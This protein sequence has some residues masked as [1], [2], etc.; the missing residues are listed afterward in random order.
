MMQKLIYL[1]LALFII[2]P[3]PAARAQNVEYAKNAL[4]DKYYFVTESIRAEGGNIFVSAIREF[5]A[6]RSGAV[7][8]V[9]AVVFNSGEKTY[10]LLAMAS[11]G[12]GGNVL[13]KQAY[14]QAVWREIAGNS[15]EKALFAAVTRYLARNPAASPGREQN[16]LPVQRQASATGFFITPALVVTNYHVVNAARQIEVIYNNKLKAAATVIAAEPASDLA[17]LAVHGLEQSVVP[18]VLGQSG[19]VREGARIY[20]V[21]FPLTDYIGSTAK[22]TEGIVSGTAGYQGDVRQFEISAPV[23]PGNS[24]GPLLNDR[25]EAIGVVAAELGRKFVAKTGIIP[26]SVNF[27]I[28]ADAIRR[29]LAKQP[30][31]P[32]LPAPEQARPVLDAV[33]IMDLAKQGIVRIV[34]VME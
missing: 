29:L 4:G 24:G 13:D 7:K 23:Q 20:A 14:P 18:L 1:L 33:S 30:G 34:V 25:G 16:A 8:R 22:I 11:L 21:G 17:L 5:G 10:R 15:G 28:K 32:G 9:F 3:W 27:A 31:N 6:E 2:L 26:Q 12:P 19:T